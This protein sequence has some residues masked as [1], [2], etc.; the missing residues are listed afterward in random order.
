MNVAAL[1]ADPL[2][3]SNRESRL[4]GKSI[5]LISVVVPVF[6]EEGNIDEFYRRLIGTLSVAE[7][8]WEVIFIDDGSGDGTLRKLDFL[9]ERDSR[10]RLLSFSRNFGHQKALTAGFDYASG[11]AVIS[12]DGDL[13]HPPELI[14][15]MLSFWNEGYDV[16]YTIRQ[17]TVG[18]PIFKKLTAGFFY[19]LMS[20]LSSVAV[21]SNAS[22]FRLVS[23]SVCE[24]LKA[25]KERERF[26]RGMIQWVGFRQKAIGFTAD[27]RYSGDS[28]YT[29]KKMA[30]FA[31]DGLLSYSYLPIFV[32]VLFAM[33]VMVAATGYIFFVLYSF[34]RGN[35][36]P[37]Q[38]SILMSSLLIGVATLSSIAINSIYVYKIYQ[39]VKGRPQYVLRTTRGFS[40]E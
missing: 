21:I 23:R 36:F 29:L 4:S 3:Q 19:G 10:V 18:I 27:K 17:E 38:T 35:A 28:G 33:L 1:H 37:G 14:P 15:V 5:K 26:Y 39:E 13:Q 25:H 16:V 7:H 32:V 24:A 2:R 22:D 9:C 6:N 11:D 34:M 31:L 30:Q 40:I 12:I 20:K 8:D